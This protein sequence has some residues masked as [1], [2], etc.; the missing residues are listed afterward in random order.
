MTQIGFFRGDPARAHGSLPLIL[1][2]VF[3]C[4]SI[5]LAL[6][7]QK[8]MLP[9]LLSLHAG[10]EVITVDAVHF[11]SVAR[12]LAEK[13]NMHGWSSWQIFPEV[14]ARGNVAVLGALYALFGNDPTLI[15]P[16][17]AALHAFGGLLIYLL[18]RELSGNTAIGTYAGLT[19]ACLFVMFPTP[20]TWYGQNHKDSY[21]I[22][23][24]LLIL[25][26]WLKAVQ[27]NYGVRGWLVLVLSNIAGL[28]L[29]ASVRPYTLI[30]LLV[31]T[32]GVLLTVLG[33]A[34]I[35][36][37][38]RQTAK[39]WSFFLLATITLAIGVKTISTYQVGNMFAYANWQSSQGW[40]WQDEELLPDSIEKYVKTA[41]KT[42]AGLIDFGLSIGAK[43]MIDEDVVP[44]SIKEVITYLP[45]AL[46][47]ALFAPFPSS[48]LEHT[49]M[50]R[51]VATGEM[52][53]YYLCLPGVLLL[54]C[55]NRK[56][57]VLL[58]IYFACFFLLIYGFTQANLGTL[59]RV[60]F[61]YLFV[62]LQLGVLGW[63]TWLD[64]SGRLAR[65]QSLLKPPRIPAE[66]IENMT[67]EQRPARKGAV[68]AGI[69]V[70]AL[71]FLSFFGFFLRDILM[72]NTFGL[73][74]SLDNF[75]IAL[76]IPMFIVTVLC[77][78]LGAAI[79]PAYMD[80]M[81]RRPEQTSQTIL[82][83]ISFLT[84]VSLLLACLILYLAGPKLLSLIYVESSPSNLVELT[85]LSNLALPILLF[86]GVVI[87]GNSVL[88]AHG[89]AV[90]TST[91][92]LV[93]PVVA[94]LALLVFGDS[95]GVKAVMVG[96]VLG[97]ILN[98]LLVQFYLK[99]HQTSLLP[100][101]GQMN[102]TELLPLFGQYLPLV[103]S[104]FFVSA[105]APVAT[106]LAMSLPAGSVSA[107]NLGTKVV[108][109][110]TGLVGAAVSA[111]MLPY[112]AGLIAKKN[113]LSA[114]RELSFFLLLATFVSVPASAV[115]FIWAEEII[116]LVFLSGSVDADS[117]A[118]I[119]RVMQY[120]VV[121]LP[122]FVCSALLL[123]FAT[124]T[125][126]LVTIVLVSVI[127]LLVNVAASLLLMQHMGVAGIALGGSISILT[128]TVL[129]VLALVRFWH[130]DWL[131]AVFILLNWLLFLTLLVSIHFG[132]TPS[133]FATSA[134]YATLLLGYFSSLR[135]GSTN[136]L[137]A[138]P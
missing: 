63:F 94:I 78:P 3:F 39:T 108:L 25:L 17:N 10:A 135:P 80:S 55:Y 52:I 54:L 97:Q 24:S 70:M 49:S 65:L 30:I 38:F 81:E 21:V 90:L 40:Q 69:W 14:S 134:A 116:N 138:S 132:S 13:I 112:F 129:L 62:I 110:V 32:A 48:W 44:R 23:G 89:R 95:Y 59:Y 79:I 29:I 133:V 109:F 26:T 58:T 131:D 130:I 85:A 33:F 64:K 122:F 36:R 56:P 43:S 83:N 47:I 124:A 99:P 137:R 88:N 82:P 37:Q 127:G 107:L 91:V 22:V 8:V 103:I 20:L 87:L 74:T 136:E 73:G 71:T 67:A 120:A 115:L 42:R 106:L 84:T 4:Y 105:V 101:F 102:K 11:D 125:R 100:R 68:N 76:L 53:I 86:S 50:S 93:V 128:S 1:W 104:A 61:G 96:M 28:V 9:F 6:I 5:C 7:F 34:L 12:S 46:Q 57:A 111:V 18:A 77:I 15:I 16:V 98:L 19:A 45:R 60:R 41:A 2:V 92:Q 75:F 35:R 123:K 113:L 119:A 51:L 66:P 114:R 117:Q 126:H 72:A 121:Q 27:M 118:L 31:A